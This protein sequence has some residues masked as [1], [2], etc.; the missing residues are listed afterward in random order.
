MKT[1][2]NINVLLVDDKQENLIALENILED[3]GVHVFKANSG[4]EALELLLKHGFALALVDVQMPEMNGF[5]LAELMRGKEATKNIPLIFVTAGAI[6]AKHTFK[7]YE[8]G[9][10]D[11]LYKPLNVQVVKSKVRVFKALEQQ[12][13]VIRNQL[14]SLSEAIRVRD[15]FLSIASHELKTP[16][17][18]IRLQM[19]MAERQTTLN[20]GK[21]L[22]PEKL[23]K[24]FHTTNNQL[25]KLTRL[26]NDL[27]DTTR[28]RAGKLSMNPKE[29]NFSDLVKETLERFMPQLV[30]ADCTLTVN[31]A[32]DVFIWA[33]PLRVEQVLMN[34]ISNV[35]KYAPASPVIVELIE[36]DGHGLFQIRDF[37]MG[38]PKNKI[39]SIFERFERAQDHRG[40]SGLGLGLYIV[41]QI[42]D[43]HKGSIQ[44]ESDEGKGCLFKVKFPLQEVQIKSLSHASALR[45]V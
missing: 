24:I 23:Q 35:I 26:I 44:V 38:I 11:F 19:Q 45:S 25:N 42:M 1:Q 27:L 29:I 14:E 39:S 4:R 31:I 37:G 8:A 5:E 9:A 43:A 34:L 17:T 6:D 40:V 18:S 3:E 21:S 36:F 16:I 30:N 20:E 7:G 10:V 15:D 33:D 32:D 2:N 12:K 28:I 13:M 22:T 41:K